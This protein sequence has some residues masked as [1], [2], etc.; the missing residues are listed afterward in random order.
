MGTG[1]MGKNRYKAAWTLFL[2]T[3]FSGSV[4]ADRIDDAVALSRS[5]NR[6]LLAI[7]SAE[8]CGPC[9]KLHQT[10]ETDPQLRPILENCVLLEMDSQTQEFRDFV[11]R[12]PA[13]A[14]LIPMVWVV[15]P[16]GTP[17]YAQSGGMTG[18]QLAGLL[19]QAIG[20]S[21]PRVQPGK[22][23]LASAEVPVPAN[24]DLDT[25]LKSARNHAQNGNLIDAI[26]LVSPIAA[27]SG[28]SEQLVKAR[29]YEARL[30]SVIS[31]WMSELGNQLDK[32]ESVH[33]AAYRIAELYVELTDHPTLR[34]EANELLVRFETK[35]S[36]AVAVQQAKFLLKARFF[37]DKEDSRTAAANYT[38][39]VSLDS[40]TPA[41][42]FASHRLD[43]LQ[44]RHAVKMTAQ[45]R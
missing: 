7:G 21:G 33:G 22:T 39:V 5:T 3:L 4:S 35:P 36:T 34:N 29:T 9:R 15:L 6:P 24:N 42:E 38:A 23:M 20:Y 16:N 26:Q 30:E 1:A 12:F 11:N 18:T 14:S 10:I 40:K 27:M 17:I 19:D 8:F 32:N 41:A 13:D 31:N 45:T 28:S 43:E 44:E 25:I 37:E 2:L